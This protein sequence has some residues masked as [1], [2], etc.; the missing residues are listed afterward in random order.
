MVEDDP[1]AAWELKLT[2]AGQWREDMRPILEAHRHELPN[3]ADIADH[4]DFRL[5]P[6]RPF[7]ADEFPTATG[8]L[9]E[10]EDD[11]PDEDLLDRTTRDGFVPLRDFGC[12]EYDLLVLSGPQAGR[13]WTLTDGGVGV[14]AESQT[15]GR[16]DHQLGWV[17]PHEVPF[18]PAR[19]DSTAREGRRRE[20]IIKLV[21]AQLPPRT[22]VT[23]M[24]L[25]GAAVRVSA[26]LPGAI[27]RN[28]D[29]APGAKRGTYDAQ[30][31][32][33]PINRPRQVRTFERAGVPAKEL[34]MLL[35]EDL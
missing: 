6:D 27:V 1:V 32:T 2:E 19:R 20:K 30:V 14:I 9:W 8:W 29:L 23:Y 11:E 28:V 25:G 13:I 15:G 12:G 33:F 7:P 34:G 17:S 35:T 24:S 31:H 18:M 16:L 21:S 3:P 5:R 22:R 26:Y 4:H 10:T